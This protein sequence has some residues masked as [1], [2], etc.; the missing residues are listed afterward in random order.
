MEKKLSVGQNALLNSIGSLF[1]LGCQWLITV[2]VIRIGSVED[3]GD[4]SLAMSITNIFYTLA[5]FGMREFQVSDYHNK[6]STSDYITTRIMTCL[7]SILLCSAV[8]L[9]NR[10]YSGAQMACI[11]IYMLFRACE[12]LIDTFQ[13]IEQK[14]D[15][16]DYT[17]ISFV[18]RG[19]LLLG[20]SEERR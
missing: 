2:L 14:A 12:A 3:G 17:C 9:P 1:Y 19:I 5:A 20:R 16:M 15:R 13:A 6:H 18:V 7:C 10:H 4:L 8:I 11:L